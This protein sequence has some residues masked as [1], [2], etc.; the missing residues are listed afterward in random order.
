M[1]GK[2][3]IKHNDSIRLV[4]LAFCRH[5][6]NFDPMRSPKNGGKQP[7]ARQSA[8]QIRAV[9]HFQSTMTLKIEKDSSLCSE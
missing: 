4:W 7:F 5:T 6:R 2:K 9:V 8:A 3:E 1:I